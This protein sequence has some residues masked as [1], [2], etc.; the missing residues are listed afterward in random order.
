MKVCAGLPLRL[1]LKVLGRSPSQ[2]LKSTLAAVA[3]LIVAWSG[4]GTVVRTGAFP[5][6]AVV[7]EVDAAVAGRLGVVGDVEGQVVVGVGAVEGDVIPAE[8]VF[9]RWGSS[10]RLAGVVVD[11]SN[12]D[13]AAREGEANGDAVEM[14]EGGASGAFRTVHVDLVL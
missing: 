5:G 9:R 8:R 12:P 7:A 13:Q 14:L 2:V 11:V 4:M 3:R 1:T 10:S 6:V